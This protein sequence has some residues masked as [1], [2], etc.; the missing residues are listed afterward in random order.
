MKYWIEKGIPASK[1]VLG[2]PFFGRTFTLKYSNQTEVGAP[3]K[4]P[5]KEG[6][7]TQHPGL[8][9]YFEIC[10]LMF[11][12]D[13]KMYR[14]SFGFPYMVRGDQWIGFDDSQSIRQKVRCRLSLLF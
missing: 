11:N 2:I 7:Y 13:W 3:V 5:G 12:E 8:L 14:D 9:A 4:G 1:I 6:F 10:D